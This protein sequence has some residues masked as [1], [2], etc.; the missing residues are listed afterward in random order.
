MLQ[1]E[2]FVRFDRNITQ[3]VKGFAIIF[4]MILHCYS[5]DNY[6]VSLDRSFILVGEYH[7][8]CKICVAIF[9]FMVGYGYNFSKSKDWRYGVQHVKKLLIP[10]WVILFLFTFPVCFDRV[11]ADHVVNVIYNVF[12]IDSTYNY[13]SWFVYFYIFAMAVMPFVSRFIDKSPL[14]NTLIVLAVTV[15]MALIIHEAPRFLFSDS[16]YVFDTPPYLALFNCFLTS[17]VMVLGY[18]FAHEGYFERINLGRISRFWTL[19]LGVGLFVA[20]FV[21]RRYTYT[22]L[23]FLFAPLIIASIAIL[24][25][26]FEW[27]YFRAVMIKIGEV[28]VYMWFFHALFYTKAVRWFYQPAITVFDDINLVVLWTILLTFCASWLLKT[29][30]DAIG[31]R[32]P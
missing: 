6:D 26:K 8:T 15:A 24:F 5:A 32:L 30:V 12:G 9:V 20:G 2:H 17:P 14:R 29:V 23:D 25:N 11:C 19:V 3:I 18:L 13:F 21:L 1:D 16:N 10:F 7:R 27:R 28:S 22:L 4:M 31:K